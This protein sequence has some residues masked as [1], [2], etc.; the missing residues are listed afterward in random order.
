MASQLFGN[1][2][3]FIQWQGAT[4]VSS[5]LRTTL[6]SVFSVVAAVGISVFL[7]FKAPFYGTNAKG[8]SE[9]DPENKESKSTFTMV[10]ESIVN[11]VKLLVTRDMALIFTLFLYS[12]FVLSFYSGIYPT[13]VGN[14]KNLEESTATVGL[15]GVFTGAGEVICGAIFV[16]GSKLTNKI[17]RHY[18]L[19]G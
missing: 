1:L 7:F 9:D 11:A 8:A 3:V 16:F 14:S 17:K 6:F 5:D 15:V 2:Y 13:S 18:L 12:G 19:M 4:Y 10:M